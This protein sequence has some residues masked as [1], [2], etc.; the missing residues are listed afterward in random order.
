MQIL[1]LQVLVP[2]L[3]IVEPRVQSIL[4]KQLYVCP[5][6]DNPTVRQHR[7]PICESDGRKPN[8]Q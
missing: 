6:F 3:C 7:D 1:T 5:K 8:G 4:R 2:K